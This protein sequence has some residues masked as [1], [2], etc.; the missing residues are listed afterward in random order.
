M[1]DEIEPPQGQGE[2]VPK[3]AGKE[4]WEAELNRLES[5]FREAGLALLKHAEAAGCAVP[6]VDNNRALVAVI[7]APVRAIGMVVESMEEFIGRHGEGKAQMAVLMGRN[8][9]I[10]G[11]A[12]VLA[13]VLGR[14]GPG[15]EEDEDDEECDCPACVAGR[16]NPN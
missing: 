11:I 13:Q 15:N 16:A 8:G 9:T 5:V 7:G 10:G 1:S 2:G 6:F 12:E 14:G 4:A 3:S